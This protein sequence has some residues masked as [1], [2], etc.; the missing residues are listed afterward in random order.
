MN[1][2]ENVHGENSTLSGVHLW[3]MS[4]HIEMTVNSAL[5]S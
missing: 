3:A 2:G 5:P 1:S 4:D